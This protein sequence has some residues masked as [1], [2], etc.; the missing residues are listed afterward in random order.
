MTTQTVPT[1][2][3]DPKT[4][5]PRG[6]KQIDST[7]I[8]ITGKRWK[9]GFQQSELINQSEFSNERVPC[10]SIT[11][12]SHW[13]MVLL[14]SIQIFDCQT[15]QDHYLILMVFVTPKDVES[16][17]TSLNN[18]KLKL[19]W[20]VLGVATKFSRPNIPVKT[21]LLLATS[22]FRKF[23]WRNPTF[24]LEEISIFLLKIHHFRN[25]KQMWPS[26]SWSPHV[27]I[28][29]EINF[30]GIQGTWRCHRAAQAPNPSTAATAVSPT[31]SPAVLWQWCCHRPSSLDGVTWKIHENWGNIWCFL[32]FGY[33]FWVKIWCFLLFG[34][35]YWGK[36][37]MFL[38]FGYVWC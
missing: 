27:E 35:V 13:L 8:T 32:L 21:A 31:P 33:V 29:I 2:L 11:C 26:L 19:F 5:C 17:M 4:A 23:E 6:E 18:E 3:F 14:G 28:N 37:L 25:F 7:T 30:Q 38:V 12:W 20:F 22:P 15:M 16:N 24:P 9:N 10:V 1:A 34:Y 36:N